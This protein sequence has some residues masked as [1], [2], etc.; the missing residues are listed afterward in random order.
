M[1]GGWCL[2]N[3]CRNRSLVFKSPPVRGPKFTPAN[4]PGKRNP[5][6]FEGAVLGVEAAPLDV[7]AVGD[8]DSAGV[9]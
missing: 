4:V 1:L 7:E 5:P 3:K 8:V 2:S 6:R 9:A